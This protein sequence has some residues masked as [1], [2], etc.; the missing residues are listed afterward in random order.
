MYRT[1]TTD[2]GADGRLLRLEVLEIEVHPDRTVR[3]KTVQR[4][5]LNDIDV[6]R[7]Y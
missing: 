6:P 5:E 7:I 2:A 1:L 4:K 3:R